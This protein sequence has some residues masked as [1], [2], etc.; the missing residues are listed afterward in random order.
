MVLAY[1]WRLLDGNMYV[2]DGVRTELPGD[3][4]PGGQVALDADRARAGS[5][6]KLTFSA[7]RSP[8]YE[9]VSWF[10]DRTGGQTFR[11][12]VEVVP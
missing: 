12:Q 10:A 7:A 3:L 5:T 4:A 1:H 8:S 11:A 9:Y 2:L 6:G